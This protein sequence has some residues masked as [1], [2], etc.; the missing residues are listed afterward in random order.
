M[1]EKGISEL[2]VDE[3]INKIVIE[4]DQHFTITFDD[5]EWFS[6]ISGDY[7]PIHMNAE[8]AAVTPYGKQVVYGVLG[9]LK[10]I[11][12]CIATVGRT[13]RI[14]SLDVDF[15]KSVVCK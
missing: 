3:V 11:D 4:N 15:Q 1:T 13:I 9:V 6:V 5:M 10:A 8:Y 2:T 14:T 12:K 7:N